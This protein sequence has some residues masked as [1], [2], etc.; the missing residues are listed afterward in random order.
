LVTCIPRGN[1]E[2]DQLE[3]LGFTP[4]EIAKM[5]GKAAA[6]RRRFIMLPDELWAT[7]LTI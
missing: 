5:R 3:E 7:M 2:L 1:I 6:R 4:E